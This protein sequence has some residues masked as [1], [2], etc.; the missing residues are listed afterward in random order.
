MVYRYQGSKFQV[1]YATELNIR[2]KT[3]SVCSK[4]IS[5]NLGMSRVSLAS[6][7]AKN[8]SDTESDAKLE[9]AFDRLA[10]HGVTLC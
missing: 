8:A 3:G 9:E 6:V 4:I 10:T 7:I 5:G 2:D 1:F